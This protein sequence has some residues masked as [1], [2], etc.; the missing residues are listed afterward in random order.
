MSQEEEA[1]GRSELS[2]DVLALDCE[3]AAA[4]CE[5]RIREIVFK[6]LHKKGAVVRVRKDGKAWIYRSAVSPSAML[7]K[8]IRRFLDVAFDGS[9]APLVAQLAQMDEVTVED[10]KEIEDRVA[11]KASQKPRRG[12]DVKE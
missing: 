10:L 11:Q 2:F 3:R 9:A 8:E 4:E 12:K 5:A 1:V 6:R 7:R